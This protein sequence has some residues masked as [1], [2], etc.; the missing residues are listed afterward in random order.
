MIKER[1][2][3]HK[4]HSG[5]LHLYVTFLCMCAKLLQLYL[6]LSYPIGL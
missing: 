4:S 3:A 6:T 5:N 1:H 2:D